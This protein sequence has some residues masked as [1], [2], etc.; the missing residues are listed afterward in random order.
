VLLNKRIL[1]FGGKGGV[2]KTTCAAAVAL[3]ASRSGKRVLLVSTDPAHSTSDIFEKQISHVESEICPGLFAMELDGE[4]E[5]RT[6]IETVKRQISTIFSAT[7]VREAERQIELAAQMPGVED[8]A[9]FDRMSDLIVTRYDDYDL[10]V[11]DTAP[12]GHSLRL[13]R[14]PELLSSWIGALSRRRRGIVSLDRNIDHVRLKPENAGPV[15]DDPILKALESRGEKLDRV[16]SRLMHHNETGFVLVLIP[17]KLPIEE[18]VRAATALAEA[19]VNV[20]GV[21]V[22]RVLPDSAEGEFYRS[23][24]RQ[25]QIY[26]DEI[27]RRL[28]AYRL[29][30]VPQFE[31]DVYGMESLSRISAALAKAPT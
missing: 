24:R 15:S 27:I 28:G 11:F 21:I 5:A 31:T 13:L 2:G 12:T 3:A 20:C 29:Q 25:E 9:L 26:R 4:F 19:N 30:W 18:S 7:I 1:F 22:N 16:R 17:E 8:V 14:M 23:R 6:Y 10:L